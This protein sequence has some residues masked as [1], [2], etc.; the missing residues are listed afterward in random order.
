MAAE[1][2]EPDFYASDV[3]PQPNGPV[4]P[5]NRSV[6]S[7]LDPVFGPGPARPGPARAMNSQITPQRAIDA[8]WKKFSLSSPAKVFTIL[9]HNQRSSREARL[10]RHAKTDT[11]QGQPVSVSY[12]KAVAECR[13]KVD[14]IK[15]ECYALNQKY[16]DPYFNI[17]KD[18]WVD[19]NC[20][21]DT[22]MALGD[23]KMELVPLSVKRIEDIFDDPKFYIEGATAND[24]RQGNDGD[25]W[26]LSAL[27]TLSSVKDLIH[28][29]CVARDEKVGVYG[30]VFHRDGEWFSEIID[31]KLFLTKPDFDDLTL[32][33]QNEWNTQ[34]RKDP[35]DEYRKAFQ[36]GSSALYFAQCNDRNETWLPL[37]EKAYAKAHGDY[38]VIDGGWSGEAVED[39]T[40]GITTELYA[41]DIID[42][43]RFWN[44]ELRQVNKEFLFSC[45][46]RSSANE[47]KKGLVFGHAYSIL[48]AVE[49]TR[50]GRLYRLVKV[51]NPWGDSEWSGAWSDGSK[52]WDGYWME[53]LKHEFGDD[54]IFWISYE[55]LLKN[56]Q[57]FDRTRLFYDRWTVTQQWTSISVPWTLDYLDT[58]F[59]LEVARA[60]PT[61][62]VLSQLDDRYFRGLEG[63]YKFRLQFRLHKGDEEDYTIR[64]QANYSMRRS[65]CAEVDLQP[66]IYHI[67][68]RIEATR[69]PEKK[70]PEKVIPAKCA[71]RRE[72]LLAVGL[73]YDLAHAKGQFKE[74]EAEKR[75]REKKE[76][77]EA[78]KKQFR[79][80][81]ERA[82]RY[83]LIQKVKEK[84]KQ[85]KFKEK[86][87]Q[88]EAM[89]YATELPAGS[90]Q[91]D[92]RRQ[93]QHST[94]LSAGPRPADERRDSQ[95]SAELSP[96][97]YAVDAQSDSQ[98]STEPDTE[99]GG[100]VDESKIRPQVTR[101]LSK[102]KYDVNPTPELRAGSLPP[103]EATRSARQEEQTS[104][105]APTYSRQA[106]PQETDTRRPSSP[107]PPPPPPQ[108]APPPVPRFSLNDALPPERPTLANISDDEASWDSELDYPSSLRS[109]SSS[110]SS[111]AGAA[112]GASDGS[113]GEDFGDMPAVLDYL[114]SPPSPPPAAAPR[115]S[116]GG[117][118]ESGGSSSVPK[119]DIGELLEDPW[120]AVCVVG[121]RVFS[122]GGEGQED[123]VRVEVVK[124]GRNAAE[125]RVDVDDAAADAIRRL[126]IG[127][128]GGEKK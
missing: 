23:E 43:N 12:D 86:Q 4:P 117:V 113:G 120:N 126:E 76:K 73:S 74:S 66:G 34:Y 109:T 125:K 112:G 24:I 16:R 21:N 123:G 40:G 75:K 83:R 61:V 48:D 121:L 8:F 20:F 39:L 25:C 51:R 35:E 104:T 17:E 5:D 115:G 47:K 122:Q 54:G 2:P 52:E 116:A 15:K 58:K 36:R 18:W 119:R 30:F 124:P 101:L 91:V 84:R 94:E 42:K 33:Q 29:V 26:F 118:G 100:E 85:I 93:R 19:N 63:Q 32:E 28:R 41:T 10:T 46:L 88:S 14:T 107:P 45:G 11:K 95:L 57:D 128:E 72:K 79:K 80:D 98:A 13:A 22:L 77:K 90:R 96:G 89:R 65:V 55:D 67:V 3:G 127:G 56:F 68:I 62:I 59:R 1:A 71:D 31:D 87:R 6:G 111:A 81:N 102:T 50:N 60:G 70:S 106:P 37:L 110:S 27:S 78:L 105:A 108:G 44:Q 69:Y 38:A 7:V 64:S 53:T 99:P 92:P 114:R 49:H 97:L 9:P 103:I 82:R